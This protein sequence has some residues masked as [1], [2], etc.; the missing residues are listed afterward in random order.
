MADPTEGQGGPPADPSPEST[1]ATPGTEATEIYSSGSQPY[2]EPPVE[3]IGAVVPVEPAT[4]KPVTKGEL[5]R[6]PPPPPPPPDDDDDDPE[7]EG[8]LRM[9]FMEHLEELRSRLLKAILGLVVAFFA[10][11]FFSKELWDIVCEPA[12]AALTHLERESS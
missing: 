10:S 9:S 12:V 3:P 6:K 11:M 4:P 1:P 7:E 5:T 8:M 2:G